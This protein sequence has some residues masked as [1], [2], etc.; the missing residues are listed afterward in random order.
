MSYPSEESTVCSAIIPPDRVQLFPDIFMSLLMFYERLNAKKGIIF[1]RF[2]PFAIMQY[3]T[4]IRFGVQWCLNICLPPFVV[5]WE[6]NECISSSQRWITAHLTASSKRKVLLIN[7]VFPTPVYLIGIVRST[8]IAR[9]E[10]IHLS[11]YQNM[12]TDTRKLDNNPRINLIC[13]TH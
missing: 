4:F 7:E 10:C 5:F 12:K 9:F 8:K 13:Y 2:K 1:T 3:K 11:D 6:L